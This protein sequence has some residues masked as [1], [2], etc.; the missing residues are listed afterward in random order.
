MRKILITGATGYIGSNLT[1]RL[2]DLGFDVHIIIRKRSKLDKLRD[3]LD[4]IQIFEYDYDLKKLTDYLKDNCFEVV[5]HLASFYVAE[6][7]PEHIEQLIDSNIK[8]GTYILEAMRLSNTKKLINVGTSWQNYNNEIYNPVCLYA[9]TKEAFEKILEYYV[10]VHDFTVITLILYDTYGPSDDRG[11]IL[12]LLNRYSKTGANLLISPGEQLLNLT[13]ID[14]IIDGFIKA[15]EYI[16]NLQTSGHY[17][18]TLSSS[19]FITLKELVNLFQ[20]VSGRNINAIWGGREYRKREVFVPI[21]VYE[22][23]PGWQPKISLEE[24]IRLM[25]RLDGEDM[26]DKK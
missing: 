19:N 2:V 1:K 4:R 5:F 7:L 23:L 21:K 13:Y 10:K 14:D 17:K 3:Y 12:S 11:K 16:G 26:D 6:H 25:L 9:A 18:Y 8:F 22:N 24:G 20:K 15:F